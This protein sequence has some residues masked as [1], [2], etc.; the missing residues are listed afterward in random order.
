MF[1]KSGC[2]FSERRKL[3]MAILN[4]PNAEMPILNTCMSAA[5]FCG[6]VESIGLFHIS[7]TVRDI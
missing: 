1:Q 5:A 7:V 2:M 6:K 3:K 4:A